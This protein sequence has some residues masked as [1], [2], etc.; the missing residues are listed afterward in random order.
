M[1]AHIRLSEKSTENVHRVVCSMATLPGTGKKTSWVTITREGKFSDPRYGTFEITHD[2]LLSM[3][4]NFDQKIIGQDVFL[5]VSHKFEDGAAAKIL[6]LSVEGARLRALVEWTDFGLDAVQKRGFTYLSAEYA[7]NWVDN[8]IGASHGPTLLGAGL[9]VRPVIKSL[10]P[11][12]LSSVAGGDV[13][14]LAELAESILKDAKANMDAI[15]KLKKKLSE[16]GYG[17]PVIEQILQLA[18]LSIT[19]DTPPEDRDKI[20]QALTDTAKTLAQIPSSISTSEQPVLSNM[21]NTQSRDPLTSQAHA[22]SI[23]DVQNVVDKILSDK[24]KAETEQKQARKDAEKLLSEIICKAD[25]LPED[26]KK[27]LSDEAVKLLPNG[28]SEEQIKTL[29]NHQISHGH[30]L[31]AAKT[32]S[33]MGYQVS[34]FP[35]ISVPDNSTRQLSQIYHDHL[36]KTS[37]ANRLGLDAKPNVF[38]EKVL[39]EFDRR[40][41][42]ELS[43]ESKVLASNGTMMQNTNLPYGLMREVIRESLSDLNVLNLVD[44]RTDFSAQQTTQ[45]PYET[46][47]M[48]EIVNSGIVSEGRAVPFAGVEQHMDMAYVVQMKLALSVTNEVVHFTRSSVINWD[49]LGRNIET[50][51]RIMRELI[52]LRIINEIQR[53]CDS[54][55]ASNVI[56]ESVSV[57]ANTGL[58]RTAQWPVVRPFQA[59]D[60]QGDPINAPENPITITVNGKVAPAFD[61]SGDQQT[62]IYYRL[63]NLNYGEIQ[64]VDQTG[65]PAQGISSA[66]IGYSYATNVIKFDLDA[67]EGVSME[68]HLNKLLQKV[69]SQKASLSSTRYVTPNFMLMSPTLNDTITN[70]EQFIVSLKRNGTDTAANGD[71]AQIKDIPAFGTNASN[72][73]MGDCRIIMGERGTTSYTVV[74]PFST[75]DLIEVLNGKGQP[76]GKKVAYGEE[77]NAIHTPKP[78][79]NR[80]ASIVVYSS[81]NL[82][83][84]V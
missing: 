35:H 62:G 82:A 10:D 34:G 8:E 49:A 80:Y 40:F 12:T 50:N 51:A 68:K 70:A 31:M 30:N 76:L 18:T 19:K 61:G 14:I 25:G 53:A 1:S 6:Q 36:K 38:V 4:R 84:K 41:A 56:S 21:N 2:M 75:G 37:V 74:K 65:N 58:F 23:N 16:S 11:V 81:Q 77:Y 72:T 7:D 52:A 64:L 28:A 69:G 48:S 17:E 60:L 13:V 73:D 47:Q 57:N 27:Q 9:T 24:Q 46:R 54:Y 5:D 44:T 22:L 79:R 32:L 59:I 15:E 20:L 43:N 39:S 33:N 78:T 55:L 26:I 83:G 63:I 3:V 42:L 66:T 45:I 67:P 71:L 29:A